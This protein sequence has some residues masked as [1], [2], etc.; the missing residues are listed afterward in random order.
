[1]ALFESPKDKDKDEDKV[2]YVKR[3]DN[4]VRLIEF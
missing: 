4:N 1:M 3:G 2:F